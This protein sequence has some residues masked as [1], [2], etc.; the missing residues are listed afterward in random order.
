M[1]VRRCVRGGLRVGS[2]DDDRTAAGG[3]GKPLDQAQI[4]LGA[5]AVDLDIERLGGGAGGSVKRPME[6]G[7]YLA[8][9]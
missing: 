6:R 9:V 3:L 4:T 7:L 2:A 1:A 8:F 5:R